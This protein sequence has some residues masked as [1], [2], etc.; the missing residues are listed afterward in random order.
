MILVKLIRILKTLIPK[1]L[2]ELQSRCNK[3]INSI[4]KIKESKDLS[5][6]L[7]LGPE[8]CKKEQS[9]RLLILNHLSLRRSIFRILREVAPPK[10]IMANPMAVV[11]KLCF[12]SDE[13]KLSIIGK[14]S[15]SKTFSLVNF[16]AYGYYNCLYSS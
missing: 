11:V 6:G 16:N 10:K 8:Y 2:R 4:A 15:F 13:I 7:E 1:G 5:L 3:S 12:S 14:V 9:N